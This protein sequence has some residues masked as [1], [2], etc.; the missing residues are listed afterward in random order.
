MVPGSLSNQADKALFFMTKQNKALSLYPHKYPHLSLSG[1]HVA[2]NFNCSL[3][4][5]H[6]LLSSSCPLLF[7]FGWIAQIAQFPTRPNPPQSLVLLRLPANWQQ[8][9]AAP[10][11]FRF[12]LNCAI[13][14]EWRSARSHPDERGSPGRLGVGCSWFSYVVAVV[15]QRRA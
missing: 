9:C 15:V 10:V 14:A 5:A 11:V 13:C 6:R 3:P 8:F 12:W 1:C 2:D 4:S 7:V